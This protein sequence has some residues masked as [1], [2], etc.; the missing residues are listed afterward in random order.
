MN[1]DVTIVPKDPGEQ[2]TLIDTEILRS[3]NRDKA[4]T[5]NPEQ[6]SATVSYTLEKAFREPVAMPKALSGYGCLT[7]R[8]NEK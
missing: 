4:G 3:S 5:E 1:S 6:T 7:S 2:S 8:E